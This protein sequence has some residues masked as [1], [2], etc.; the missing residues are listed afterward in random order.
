M[1]RI[2]KNRF[3]EEAKAEEIEKERKYIKHIDEKFQKFHN[4]LLITSNFK[5]NSF[6]ENGEFFSEMLNSTLT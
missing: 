3:R 1:V 6:R 2:S 4:F 5:M